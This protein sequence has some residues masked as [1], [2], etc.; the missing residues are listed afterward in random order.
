[1]ET[2][3]QKISFDSTKHSLKEFNYYEDFENIKKCF[4]I[5][6]FS[7]KTAIHQLNYIEKYIN[8]NWNKTRGNKVLSFN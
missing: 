6:I 7:K 4:C 8:H 1:M 2:L 5:E 3:R